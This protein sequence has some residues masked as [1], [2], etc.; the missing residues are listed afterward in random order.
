[1]VFW[2]NVV[3]FT[4]SLFEFMFGFYTIWLP[5]FILAAVLV[6]RFR[7]PAWQRLHGS[8]SA[9]T[10]NIY[11][12]ILAGML[13]S[14]N[15]K[16][17]RHTAWDLLR[18]GHAAATVITYLI[19]SRN[20]TIIFFS[21]FT[22]SL[23]IEFAIGH[24]LGSL[25]MI[26]VV[27]L[28]LGF[29]PSRFQVSAVPQEEAPTKARLPAS[30]F[31]SWSELL[32]SKAGWLSILKYLGAEVRGFAAALAVGIGIAGTVFAAGMEHWWVPFADIA[33]HYT[34][35]SDVLNALTGPVISA[36]LFLAPVGNLP[37]IHALFK[38][39]G[40]AY[41]GII[42]FCLASVIHPLDLRIYFK[43]FGKKQGAVLAGILYFSAVL[44]G[45][46]STLVYALVNFRPQLPPLEIF[47]QV[48]KHLW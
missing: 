46:G 7:R 38:T 12:A 20:L 8:P 48:L 24:I 41:P 27:W 40:L 3:F 43:T 4:V 25:I 37:V 45:L 19:A 39:D 11:R 33:G 17:S 1:M 47:K 31:S 5:G 35:T 10:V 30:N 32:L 21:I 18:K 34:L 29:F 28:T 6:L 22:L 44:G 36:G 42:S 15:R 16:T 13:G 9:E 23:G 2:K 26:G 14:P